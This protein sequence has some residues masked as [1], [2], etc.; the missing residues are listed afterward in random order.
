QLIN[1]KTRDT[2]SFIK[3]DT[4]DWITVLKNGYYMASRNAA[5]T[6]SY[7]S[8]MDVYPFEQFDLQYNRPDKVLAAI[9]KASPTLIEA[10]HKAYLKRIK[11]AGIDSSQFLNE[12]EVPL[13]EIT[14]Q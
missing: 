4:L 11:R 8:G 6:I 10:Y 12:L 14:N 3:I 5:K 7:V 2:V 13:A 9:G 1:N